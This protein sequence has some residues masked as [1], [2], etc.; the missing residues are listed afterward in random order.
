MPPVMPS[1][2]RFPVNVMDSSPV[3]GTTI[4]RESGGHGD[5]GLAGRGAAA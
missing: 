1:R 2:M 4:L 3:K 5:F